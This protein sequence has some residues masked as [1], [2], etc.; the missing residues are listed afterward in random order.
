[1]HLGLGVGGPLHGS[2]SRGPVH[3]CP[4]ERLGGARRLRWARVRPRDHDAGRPRHGAGVRRQRLP[5]RTPAL[6]RP[7]LRRGQA[8]RART[9][10]CRRSRRCTACS[11]SAS[12]RLRP[13]NA[14]A[15]ARRATGRTAGLV[16]PSYDDGSGPYALSRGTGR[17]L[18]AGPRPAHR[19]AHHVADLD[20]AGRPE[21]DLR[22]RRHTRPGPPSRGGGPAPDRAPVQRTG[23][24]DRHARRPGGRAARPAR[25]RVTAANSQWVDVATRGPR[26]AGHGGVDPGRRRRSARSPPR[27]PLTARQA[28]SP[29]RPRRP[30]LRRSPSTSGSP[31]GRL[32]PPAPVAGTARLPARRPRVGYA[33]P[34]ASLGRGLGTA[35]ALRRRGLGRRAAAAPGAGVVLR[36]CWPACAATP[37]GRRRRAASPRT[38]TTA[39]SSGTPRRGCTRRCWPPSRR[40]PGR[41][42]S[43]ASTGSTRP[44]TPTRAATGWRRRPLPLGE[45]A[46][47][48]RGDAGL[49][50]HRQARDPRQRRHLAGG[51]PVLAGH[52][53]PA[54]A[55]REGLAAAEGHRRLLREPRDPQRRRLVQHPRRHPAGRVRRG[56]DDSVYTNVGAARRA[57]VR[58]RP[59]RRCW[60]GTPHP[61]WTTVA[62][63]LRVL[64]DAAP[65]VHP[66]YAGYPG[67]AVKQADVT[68]LSYPWENPQSR[69]VDRGRPRLLRA[70]H[71]PGRPVH[72]R[73]DPLDRHLRSSAP[74]A[75][76][77][78]PSPGAAST[79]SCGRRTTS[80][81]SPAAAARSPSPPGRRLPAGVPVRL[82][83]LPLAGRPGAPRP[84]PAAAADRRHRVAR[85]TGAAG[86]C[87]SPSDRGRPRS[88]WCPGRR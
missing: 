5:R 2:G 64:F 51:A 74:P 75:A 27:D 45:R 60:A 26:R 77:R 82:H 10:R 30:G 24:G 65:G 86:C 20:L 63:R 35:V 25:H 59:P 33:R 13:A 49:R 73:R 76:P 87:R 54:L 36:A 8:A 29:R 66:E 78:S 41:A 69:R 83:R 15:A 14:A 44:R 22:L 42:W 12:R 6:R 9:T 53:R 32:P 68:L 70:A 28:V 46:A 23:D 56:V 50:E 37:R 52:R 4:S 85:C 62:D 80:S 81:P 21:V 58:R 88:R 3:G 17:R 43:T 11:R 34:E 18:P 39:T 79:P 19:H 84:Q 16:H 72:D 67:D 7:G 47:R 38:A 1:M 71:R 55:G 31:P 48:Q 57:A 61:R 40:S